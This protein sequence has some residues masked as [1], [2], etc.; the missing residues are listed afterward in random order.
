M[1]ATYLLSCRRAHA[2]ARSTTSIEVLEDLHHYCKKTKYLHSTIYF[3]MGE[4]TFFTD[5]S[6]YT[7]LANQKHPQ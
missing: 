6:Q 2:F 5:F 1:T 7:L 3:C 4:D